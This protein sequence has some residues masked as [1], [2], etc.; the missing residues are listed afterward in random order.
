MTL[1]NPRLEQHAG[2]EQQ[3]P[4]TQAGWERQPGLEQ[5]A[6]TEAGSE[7]RPDF[8]SLLGPDCS[9]SGATS[10]RRFA[11]TPSSA[12]DACVTGVGLGCSEAEQVFEASFGSPPRMCLRPRPR[13]AGEREPISLAV[14]CRQRFRLPATWL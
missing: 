10:A 14:Y 13:G 2:F 6:A 3:G 4:A 12:A 11:A 7:K 5:L 1:E 8:G 9:A